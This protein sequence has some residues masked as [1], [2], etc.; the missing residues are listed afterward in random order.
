MNN[1]FALDVCIMILFRL[2]SSGLYSRNAGK[3]SQSLTG[4]EAYLLNDKDPD[5]PI[6]DPEH[7]EYS[8]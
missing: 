2:L 7:V 8:K 4:P 1:N 5:W 6:K 3:T